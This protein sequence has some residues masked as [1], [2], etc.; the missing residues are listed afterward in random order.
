[1]LMI[2]TALYCEAQP[3]IEF[4]HLKKNNQIKQFQ[5]FQN[6]EMNLIITNTGSIAAAVGVSLLCNK[7]PPSVDDFLINI[8]VCAINKK[9]IPSGTIYCCNK[10]T[11][12][13]TNRSFYPDLLYQHSFPEISI[14]TCSRI[15]T[16]HEIARCGRERQLFDMEA[17]GIYQAASYYYQPQQLSFLKIVSDY[18]TQKEINPKTISELIQKKIPELNIWLDLLKRARTKISPPFSREEEA[19]I[20]RTVENLRCSVTMDYQLRQLL[21]YHKLVH[22]NINDIMDIL[23]D[24]NRCKTKAEGKMCFE[25]LKSKLI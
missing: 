17:A 5:V 1:M 19:F 8:G 13:A 6:D 14:L 20:V 23:S 21:H 2:I 15:K 12:E 10:I 3:L 7:Y 11:E 18:G 25:Q 16:K 9:D 4:Y 24:S 22:G